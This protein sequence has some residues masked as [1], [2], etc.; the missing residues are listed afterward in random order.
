MVRGLLCFGGLMAAALIAYSVGVK[1]SGGIDLANLFRPLPEVN[2][3]YQRGFRSDAIAQINRARVPLRVEE[4][5]VDH[6]IQSFLSAFVGQ[7]P[8]PDEIELE[9][10]FNDLQARFPGAQYLAAN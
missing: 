8:H 1:P 7:H 6:E 3:T 10:V 9:S 5:G 4:A 2:E